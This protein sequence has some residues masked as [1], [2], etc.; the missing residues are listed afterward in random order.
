M[1]SIVAVLRDVAIIF[2]ALETLVVGALL[3]LLLWEVRNLAVMLR[4]ESNN[5]LKS[6]DDTA[7]TVRGTT[8]FVADTLVEPAIRVSSFAAGVS[9]VVRILARRNKFD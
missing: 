4:R 7:R 8:H 9:E 6:A 2:L 5:I 1:S 3:V